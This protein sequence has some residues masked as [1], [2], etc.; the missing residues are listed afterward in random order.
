MGIPAVAGAGVVRGGLGV[1]PGVE[2]RPL[3]CSGGAGGQQSNAAVVAQGALLC[4][5]RGGLRRLG[6]WAA[7]AHG[8]GGRGSAGRFKGRARDPGAR[9]GREPPEITAVISAWPVS[10]RR[11]RGR[12]VCRWPRAVSRGSGR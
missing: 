8:M 12:K 5:V 6:L 4:S 3:R 9:D 7:L 1:A 11:E 2:A 10:T